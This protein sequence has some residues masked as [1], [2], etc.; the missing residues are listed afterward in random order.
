[1]SYFNSFFAA[2]DIDYTKF[3]KKDLNSEEDH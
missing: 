3:E 1:M 2:D